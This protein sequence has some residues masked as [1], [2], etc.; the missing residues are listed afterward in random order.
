MLRNTN[1]RAPVADCRWWIWTV[2]STIMFVISDFYQQHKRP[3]T[4]D[5]QP[6][7]IWT[8][9]N[10]INNPISLKSFNHCRNLMKVL[11]VVW[12]ASSFLAMETNMTAVF[13][14]ICLY[15]VFLMY[16][17]YNNHSNLFLSTGF[18]KYSV[19]GLVHQVVTVLF[20]SISN[21][22][23]DSALSGRDN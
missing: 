9:A 13:E 10:R 20:Y 1:T 7:Y 5:L 11:P 4:P 6:S 8:P 3:D 18:Y 19:K 16:C 21:T 22:G 14:C 23:P 2:N 12:S 15:I 17:K